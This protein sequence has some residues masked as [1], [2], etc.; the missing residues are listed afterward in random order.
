MDGILVV[1]MEFMFYGILFISIIVFGVFELV[2]DE[3]IGLLV[4]L[5]D[6]ELLV[7]FMLK[8]IFNNDLKV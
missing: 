1:L 8:L 2:I 7:R 3:V 5:V 4:F 6:L